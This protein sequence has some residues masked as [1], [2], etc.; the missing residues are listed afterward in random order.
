MCDFKLYSPCCNWY[1]EIQTDCQKVAELIVNLFG[2]FIVIQKS[3]KDSLEFLT[4][5]ISKCDSGYVM[6]GKGKAYKIKDLSGVGFY[7]YAV[8]DKLIEGNMDE[9]YCV[10]HGGVI[11]K[12]E[13]AYCIIAPTMTGKSTFITYFALNGYDY[14]ADDY[15]FVDRVKRTIAP[16]QLPVSLR[17]ISVLGDSLK[18][19]FVVSGYNELRGENNTLVS[20]TQGSKIQHLL[21]RVLFIQRTDYNNITIMNKGDLYKCLLFNMKNALDLERERITVSALVDGISGYKL[22][23]K[24][25][26]YVKEYLDLI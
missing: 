18:K 26:R 16:V 10:F 24:N 17:D 7:L 9:R 21:T 19:H 5:T 12:G 25:L 20:L 23:Y 4:I 11:A 2:G 6:T 14:L 1:L 15:I 13:T 3:E 22:P 8:I